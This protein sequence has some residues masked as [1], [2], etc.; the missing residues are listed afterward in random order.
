MF[1]RVLLVGD[2]ERHLET[3]RPVFDQFL[4]EPLVVPTGKL[5]QSVARELP[6]DLVIAGHPV[7]DM[8]TAGFVRGL[9]EAGTGGFQIV[10]LARRSSFG[11]LSRLQGPG[12]KLVCT[13][14]G[15]EKLE[16]DIAACLKIAPRTRSRM[17]VTLDVRV[18]NLRIRRM[19]QAVN[20]SETGM[21]VRSTDRLPLGERVT[22][23][24][25][26]PDQDLPLKGEAEVVRHADPVVERLEG[27]GLRF[28]QLEARQSSRL[29]DYLRDRILREAA[30]TG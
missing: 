24:I 14:P 12:I 6:V 30:L 22:F 20:L 18:G 10:V 8:R 11:G 27:M 29:Q 1:Q 7:P 2:A 21:L 19:C 26:L 4:I 23:E 16:Q 3:L 5:A 17:M 28:G 13:D 25:P 9:R 15:G